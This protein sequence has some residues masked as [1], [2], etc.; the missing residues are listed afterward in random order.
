MSTKNLFAA[1]P[2]TL[3]VALLMPVVADAQSRPPNS[4]DPLYQQ[5]IAPQNVSVR[6]QICCETFSNFQP[7]QCQGPANFPGG[8]N[9]G[10]VSDPNPGTNPNPDSG[11]VSDPN[12]GTNP[13]PGPV[14][15]PNPGTDTDSDS[16]T[17]DIS[18]TEIEFKS[19]LKDSITSLEGLVKTLLNVLIV[20]A[21]PIVVF[22]I[23]LAGF[24]YVTAQGDPGKLEDAKRAL[25]YAI[26]GGVII[27]GATAIFEIIVNTINAFKS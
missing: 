7:N 14:S 18:E 24:K 20:L 2:S 3:L 12:P 13:N 19:P 6:P 26:I 8:S 25:V 11:P 16:G 1:I 27:V 5:C 9:D 21:A 17:Y 4:N 22:F 10:P 15:D 23:I